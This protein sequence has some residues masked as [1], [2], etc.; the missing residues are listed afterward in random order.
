[1][2]PPLELLRHLLA[3]PPSPQ[4]WQDLLRLLDACP[5]PDTLT[6]ALDYAEQH[7]Q[8]WPDA[9]PALRTLSLQ[10][11]RLTLHGVRALLDA[12][13]LPHLHSLTLTAHGDAKAAQK[14]LQGAAPQTTLY[15]DG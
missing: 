9:L 6:V 2:P 11:C 13:W 4:A 7:L 14:L 12:P 1:M 15:I 10:T 5:D 3:S 8:P